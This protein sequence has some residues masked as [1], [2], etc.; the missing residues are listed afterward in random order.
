MLLQP[1]PVL[2]RSSH[3]PALS[4]VRINRVPLPDDDVPGGGCCSDGYDI[5]DAAASLE[6]CGV[7]RRAGVGPVVGSSPGGVA[8]GDGPPI[9]PHCCGT[10]HSWL[11]I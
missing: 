7:H 5:R 10:P 9:R 6:I 4:N 1:A 2:V 11:Q 8:S 3:A